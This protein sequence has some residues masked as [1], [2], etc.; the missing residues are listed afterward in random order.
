[1]E[2]WCD[3]KT[4]F[5][6]GFQNLTTNEDTWQ[7]TNKNSNNT[8][9]KKKKMRMNWTYLAERQR[10]HHLPNPSSKT[11]K[12]TQYRYFNFWHRIVIKKKIRNFIIRKASRFTRH[13]LLVYKH[14]CRNCTWKQTELFW[15]LNLVSCDCYYYL[16]IV[17]VELT[18]I[19][20]KF[21]FEA[22][23]CLWLNAFIE[24]AS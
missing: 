9:K 15:T 7:I 8:R 23:W 4:Y 3:L 18:H 22:I 11:V 14:S 13:H 20:K 5:R 21:E 6:H 24:S 2:L 17:T 16:K 19:E 1:M 12:V 10:Q